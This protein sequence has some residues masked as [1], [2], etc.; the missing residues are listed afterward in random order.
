[1]RQQS[2]RGRDLGSQR[3]LLISRR[4]NSKW[5]GEERISYRCPI[6]RKKRRPQGWVYLSVYPFG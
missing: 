6:E 1:V 5:V 3:M 4:K 2:G